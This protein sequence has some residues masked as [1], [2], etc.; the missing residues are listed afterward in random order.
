MN[1]KM[2]RHGVRYM[3]EHGILPDLFY[4]DSQLLVGLILHDKN[5]LFRIIDEI[6]NNE[7]IENPYSEEDFDAY[8]IK[9]SDEVIV[10]CVNMPEPEE[11]PLCH[12]MYMIFNSDFDKLRYFTIERAGNDSTNYPFV[13]A[14]DADGNH[15]NFGRCT[16]EEKNDLIS[17]LDLFI[18][19]E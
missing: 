7:N 2:D 16:F 9:I 18:E 6:F 1:K 5:A 4:R 8:P 14:W 13:C 17:C 11:E 12:C 19:S 10:L 3:F 15:L